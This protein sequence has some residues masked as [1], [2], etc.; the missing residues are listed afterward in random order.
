MIQI[1]WKQGLFL[2]KLILNIPMKNYLVEF[3]GTFFLVLVIGLSGNPLAIGCILMVMVYM[4]GHVSGAH[5]NPAVTLA[6][7]MRGKI[8]AN[9]AMVYMLV[10]ILGAIVAAFLCH[11]IFG[12]TFAPAPDK[13]LNILK[14]LFIEGVFT[15]ALASV[16]L[17]VATSKNTAGNSFYGLAI[18][19]TVLAGA[20]AGGPISGGAFNPAVGTGPILIDTICGHHNSIKDLWIY[21]VGPFAGGAAAAIVFK[22]I[23]PDDV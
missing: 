9:E 20:I 10:Q 11:L 17:N 12:H 5:Y 6:V 16:V 4:G 7:L 8:K 14:P 19:F 23:N 15:F 13:S 18:G 2:P 21:L 1:T 3:I 22:F